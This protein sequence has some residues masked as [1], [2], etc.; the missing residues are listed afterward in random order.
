ML[1]DLPLPDIFELEPEEE[2]IIHSLR[3]EFSESEEGIWPDLSSIDWETLYTKTRQWVITPLFNR[4][5][6]IRYPSLIP[7]DL[8]QKIKLAYLSTF[9]TNE[10]YY[11]RLTELLEALG[12][13]GIRVILLK[14]AHLAQFVY[15]DI[16]LRPMSDVDILIKRE[17]LSTTE[18]VLIRLGY[19][20]YTS[21]NS[22]QWYK[23]NHFHLPFTHPQAI[24]HL[25]V[26]WDFV[27][28]H[29]PF[30]I[31]MEGVWERAVGVE[32]HGI[33]AMIPSPEDA[34][35]HLCFHAAHD[36]MLRGGIRPLLD[37]AMLIKRHRKE[38]RWDHLVSLAKEWRCER[39][40]Y[41]TLLLSDRLLC[42]G[43]PDRVLP[44][45]IDDTLSDDLLL[46]ALERVFFRKGNPLP[47]SNITNI[48]RF[49]VKGGLIKRLAG[50]FKEVFIPPEEMRI[51]YRL[52]S[53][54]LVY[55]Y[56]P[57]RLFTLL[58]HKLP[59]YSSL[60]LHSLRRSRGGFHG[61]S[62]ETWMLPGS[63]GRKK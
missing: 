44:S 13:T 10:A 55:L 19:E 16:G 34:I 3:S 40:L 60:L 36:D 20:Y 59:F 5:I 12:A 18:R 35:L 28:Q 37:I 8:L 47:I 46:D 33:K 51:R 58:Y 31:G 39:Y 42:A 25:E 21:T 38:I 2:F 23:T 41:I 30:N 14:G 29:S 48:E 9:I 56:Y 22:V 62:L 57:V 53:P 63:P 49:K 17:D 54:G 15:Q 61:Y 11:R 50:V 4:L 32:I 52:S 1:K 6:A 26:H 45:L 7:G 27:T 43:V 24:R